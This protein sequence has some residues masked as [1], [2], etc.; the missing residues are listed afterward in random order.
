MAAK[1]KKSRKRKNSKG[2]K[3]K[4]GGGGQKAATAEGRGRKAGRKPSPRALTENADRQPSEGSEETL[5]V[6]ADVPDAVVLGKPEPEPGL[7]EGGHGP[8][9]GTRTQVV[10]PGEEEDESAAD[11]DVFDLDEAVQDTSD[12][13]GDDATIDELIAQVGTGS[14]VAGDE[15]VG[16]RPAVGK[17]PRSS[18]TGDTRS[19]SSDAVAGQL[20]GDDT[21]STAPVG[22]PSTAEDR[23][24]L[25]A[26]A[27]AYA[28]M[29]D[30]RY[31]VP[32]DSRQVA[33][34]K[35][36]IALTGLVVAGLLAIAPPELV[37]P[38]PPSTLTEADRLHGLYVGLLL[39]A[40]QVE[41]FRTRE[42]RLPDSLAEV[43]ARVPGV[44]FVKSGNRVY[45]LIAYTR[46]GR[47]I[48]YD[49]AAPASEFEPIERA[50]TKAMGS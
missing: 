42:S 38:E 9:E 1:G 48:V 28:E 2:Q 37:S 17:V 23:A 16:E 41:A 47:A 10:A 11:L 29:Q 35:A 31:R 46:D 8:P 50:W 33:R 6:A 15:P 30:A 49:S 34:L 32:T 26:A 20:V 24:R 18:E 36:W 40:Q 25:L 13:P 27:S 14:E 7:E 3:K 5:V 12:G 21:E 43:A 22:P 44:R 39:Q 19:S 45:Q 4:A